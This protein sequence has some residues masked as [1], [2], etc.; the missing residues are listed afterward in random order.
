MEDGAVRLTFLNDGRTVAF[1]GP[2]KKLLFWDAIACKEL[3]SFDGFRFARVSPDGVIQA[4]KP[5]WKSDEIQVWDGKNEKEIGKISASGSQRPYC[6]SPDGTL[7]AVGGGSAARTEDDPPLRIW[8]LSP[9]AVFKEFPLREQIGT[10]DFSP[11]GKLM[12]TAIYSQRPPLPIIHVWEV[13]T[14]KEKYALEGKDRKDPEMV[15]ELRVSPDSRLLGVVTRGLRIWDLET[16]RLCWRVRLPVTEDGSADWGHAIAFSPNGQMLAVASAKGLIYLFES[17]TG[18]E[19]GRFEAGRVR[20]CSVAF[21]PSGLMLASLGFDRAPLIWDVTGRIKGV[22]KEPEPLSEQRLSRCWKDLGD[23]DAEKAWK[24]ICGLAAR[25]S[26]AVSLIRKNLPPR[27]KLAPSR[28]SQLL[29]DLESEDF[30]TREDAAA[31]LGKLGPIAAPSLRKF[32][33]E[34]EAADTKKRVDLILGKQINNLV[35]VEELL[36]SRALEVLEYAGTAPARELLQ[37][38]ADGEPS[39]QFTKDA[40]AACGRIAKRPDFSKK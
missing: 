12:V 18:R 11:D 16:G 27:P 23:E 28:L 14:G 35:T 38:Y 2:G 30:T 13:G 33:A 24:T 25:P 19:R 37:A 10:L 21:S 7:L 31:E 4:R 1:N 15:P 17:C 5:D 32:K 20:L 36:W 3:R 22:G 9:L 6:F 29:K 34:A 39:A 40:K 26:Q 8:T